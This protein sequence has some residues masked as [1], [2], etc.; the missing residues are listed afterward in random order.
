MLLCNIKY[1]PYSSTIK[2]ILKCCEK[3]N[4]LECLLMLHFFCNELVYFDD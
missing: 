2:K 1:F 4:A 3:R